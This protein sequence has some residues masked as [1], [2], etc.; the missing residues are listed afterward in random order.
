M[1]TVELALAFCL[2]VAAMGALAKWLPIPLPI[3]LVAGGAGLS[4][5]PGLAR[6]ELDPQVFFLLFVPPL[7][8]SDGWLFP[9]RE[10]FDFLR[11][12][13]LLAF[14]LVAATVVAVGYLMHALIPSLPLAAAFALGAIVSP[15]DAVATASVT[16][17]LPLPERVAHI[18]NGESLINDA[19]GLV[20]FKFAV[21]AVA[22]G[23]FSWVDATGQLALLAGGGALTGLV[24]A[25]VIGAIRVRLVRFCVDDPKIQTI[26]SLLTP[27]AAYLVAERLQVSGVL[28]IVASGLYAGMHDSRHLSLATRRHSWEVW[29]LLLYVFNGLAFLLLG[30]QLEHVMVGM[31]TYSWQTLLRYAAVLFVTIT[32]V[33]FVWVYPGTYLPIWLSKRIRERE[34]RR[35]PRAVFL[36]GW[37]GI[38]GSITLAA[39][40]SI[41]YV[42]ASGEPFPGRDLILFLAGATIILTL[43]VNGLTLPLIIRVLHLPRDGYAS[44]EERQARIAM[45]R[46]AADT[47]RTAIPSLHRADD[48]AFTRRLIADYETRIAREMAEGPR[49]VDAEAR[50]FSEHRLRLAAINAERTE[51]H[52]LRDSGAI[53]DETLRTIEAQIDHAESLVVGDTRAT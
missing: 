51:L 33:R 16:Q 21:A 2:A 11:P 19:S 43:C 41:P 23:T 20:A 53:N 30:L 15:T 45:T 8:F 4:Y 52:K 39:A 12:I 10:L 40:L 25:F 49:A 24:V 31:P 28:A 35:D 36:V 18:V 32:I 5:V 29:S 13:L 34:G 26:I 47:L 42:S 17:Q 27:Y 6:V 38:R 14:G 48:L 9:K 46:A 22:T 1:A 50:V 44:R 3:I 7:L 37:A